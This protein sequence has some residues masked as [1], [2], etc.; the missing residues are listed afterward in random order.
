MKVELINEILEI[1]PRDR[2][3]YLYFKDKYAI[4]LLKCLV[5]ETTVA[6]IKRSRFAG[7]LRKPI[8][9]EFVSAS[10]KARITRSDLNELWSDEI[11]PFLLTLGQWGKNNHCR[12]RHYQTTSNDANLVLQ[13]NFSNLHNAPYRRLVQDT[14]NRPFEYLGHPIA[15]WP[16]RTLAWARIDLSFDTDEA[17]IEEVQSDWIR[18]GLRKRK[19]LLERF[20]DLNREQLN[21][22]NY[23]SNVLLPHTRIW[24]EAVLSAAIWFV[25][26]EL[27]ISKIFFHSHKSGCRLKRISFGLPPR[28]LYEE[29]PKQFALKPVLEEP[30]FLRTSIRKYRF[31][32][33]FYKID[34]RKGLR[35]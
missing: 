21:E 9:R 19:S 22:L 5:E 4:D 15:R 17:L 23:L 29:L 34:F 6:E 32:T 7:F 27:G 11:V 24:K 30:G 26:K 33:K 31:E 8:L 14:S 16:F 1:L 28:S 35:Q 12:K 3:K 18:Y 25:H 10:G 2:T 20:E 13:L